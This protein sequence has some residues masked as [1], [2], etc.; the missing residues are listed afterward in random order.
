MGRPLRSQR[1]GKGSPT[2]RAPPRKFKPL[3]TYNGREG[4]VVDIINDPIRNSPLAKVTYDD[5]ST[6]YIIATEGMKV[7][8]SVSEKVKTLGDVNEGT[9]ISCVEASPNS[10]P[11]I[12]RA[13]GS[14]ATLVSKTDRYCI[15]QLPSKKTMKLNIKCRAATGVPAG[16]GRKDKPFLK[17]GSKYHLMKARGH[18]YPRTSG[19]SMNA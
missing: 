12:C 5:N 15:I 14:A 2:Y 4:R 17:A 9:Q 1:R 10:G 7:G 6:G 13:P 19:V 11:K 16:E 3:L 8:D 18:M